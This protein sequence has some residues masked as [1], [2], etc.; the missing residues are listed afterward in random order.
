MAGDR[1]APIDATPYQHGIDAAMPLVKKHAG[2]NATG[3]MTIRSDGRYRALRIDVPKPLVSTDD[4]V[5]LFEA[6]VVF[7]EQTR[8]V[9]GGADRVIIATKDHEV[10]AAKADIFD[11]FVDKIDASTFA[12]R[13]QRIR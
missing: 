12:S 4:L 3:S 5:P 1:F 7:F 10:M 9:Q 13:L 8:G 2:K 11:L 6:T